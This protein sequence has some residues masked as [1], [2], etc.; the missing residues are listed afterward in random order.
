MKTENFSDPSR[1]EVVSE[2]I[3]FTRE[4]FA[5]DEKWVKKVTYMIASILIKH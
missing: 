5:R 1:G 3:H 2:H 4:T